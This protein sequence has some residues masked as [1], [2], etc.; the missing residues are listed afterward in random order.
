MHSVS[1]R[2]EEIGKL[3]EKD[4][5]TH[6]RNTPDVCFSSPLH[7]NINITWNYWMFC[8]A[9]R[10]LVMPFILGSFDLFCFLLLSDNV[11]GFR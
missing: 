7:R 4:R 9:N 11:T 8:I 2:D 10:I 5:E 3:I 1:S 6:T